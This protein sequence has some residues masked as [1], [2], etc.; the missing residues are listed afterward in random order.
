MPAY[1]PLIPFLPLLGFL[2]IL[3]LTWRTPR[4]SGYAAILFIGAACLLS[5]LA[6]IQAISASGGTPPSAALAQYPWFQVGTATFPLGF[7]FDP[8]AATMLVVVT[9][10]SLLVQIYSQGYMAGD[11]GYSRYFAYMCLFTFSMLGIVVAPNFLQM[12]VFWELVGLSSYLLIGFWW[13]RPAA[14]AAAMKAFITTRVGDLGFLIGILI[15]FATT[16]SFDFAQIAAAAKSGSLSGGLLTAA[17]V[18]VFLG[19]VGKS[20]QFP[21]Q[22]WLPDAME[23]PTPVSALIHAAT[24]VAAGVYLVARTFPLFSASPTAMLVV[25]WIGGF[26]A[27]FAATMG[28]VM[29]DIKRVL[30]YSTI[31]QLGYMFL[32]LGVGSLTAGTFHLVSHAFFKALLFL[33]AGAVIHGTITARQPHGEQ[34]MRYLGGLIHDQPLTAWTFL[35]GALALAA[36]PPFSGFWSKDEVLAATYASG[37]IVLFLFAVVTAGLTAFYIFRAWF[38]TFLGERRAIPDEVLGAGFGVLGEPSPVGPPLD[39]HPSEGPLVG[40]GAWHSA[41]STQH[42][43][44]DHAHDAPPNMAVPLVILAAL[45]LLFGLVGSPVFGDA[46]QR[47]IAG[48]GEV[49]AINVPLAVISTGIGLLGILVAWGYYGAHWFSAEATARALRP[50]YT[51]LI[52]R[53]YMDDLYNWLAGTVLIG[54]GDGLAR[55]DRGIIDGAVNGVA[56][57]AYAVFGRLFT[58]AETGRLPNYAL[59]FFVGLVIVAGLVVGFPPGR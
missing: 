34:D 28:L 59:A 29:T 54:I 44:P 12:Y 32:G 27:I 1:L 7:L 30:A 35:F 6:L 11:P 49:A 3:V 56:W 10:V 16:R 25:A 51:L 42:L 57:L 20:A 15:L 21:L 48:P 2:V 58:R 38:L 8:L 43:D 4:F 46:F 19:A 55:F 52:N 17:M 39:A 53:Y 37:N 31:S 24:M 26:T 33:A 47:F 22:T 18:L 36:I 9:F 45:A 13:R 5:V 41:S 14:A 50:I 23:G 40:G